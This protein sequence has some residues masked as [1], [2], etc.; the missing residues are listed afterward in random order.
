MKETDKQ[1]MDAE[2]IS[3]S[4][5]EL[6]PHGAPMSLL[7]HIV[8]YQ[9][10]SLQAALTIREDSP[11]CTANGVPAYVGIEYMGQAVAAFAGWEARTQNMPITVGFLVGARKYSS[12]CAYFKLGSTLE[13][14]VSRITDAGDG[15]S[16]FACRIQGNDP[17]KA[18][19]ELSANLNVF[20]PEDVEEYFERSA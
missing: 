16:V 13:V 7:D 17:D 6:I 3:Y 1:R 20:V 18:L 10:E 9:A 14:T 8:N 15:L 12:N 5:L 4:M 2:H 19:I 11:F